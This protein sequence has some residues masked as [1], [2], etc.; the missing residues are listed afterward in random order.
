[1]GNPLLERPSTLAILAIAIVAFLCNSAVSHTDDGLPWE[2]TLGGAS[3]FAVV[4]GALYAKKVELAL[5]VVSLIGI[6]VPTYF[7]Y[8]Y[9]VPCSNWE[10]GSH[11]PLKTT[12]SEFLTGVWRLSPN[13][14][15]WDALLPGS[16]SVSQLSVLSPGIA[17]T[18]NTSEI[19][20]SSMMLSDKVTGAKTHE[21]LLLS[22]PRK[23]K[24]KT[25]SIMM[26]ARVPMR[27][28]VWPKE[29]TDY[30]FDLQTAAHIV[31][32]PTFTGELVK[33]DKG[34]A[35]DALAK[36]QNLRPFMLDVYKFEFN[37]GD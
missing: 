27:F 21:Y 12:Q 17:V 14:S 22:S 32:P 1:M 2:I 13:T 33:L 3:V 24:G 7:V 9:E 31:A 29:E 35:I 20:H 8:N 28:E 10:L 11:F 16:L 30:S 26:L 25:V 34:P 6:C 23:V 36:K 4:F 37:Y 19:Y 15:R 5:S 18:V